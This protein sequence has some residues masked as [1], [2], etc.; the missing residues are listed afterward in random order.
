[1]PVKLLEV[2]GKQEKEERPGVSIVPGEVLNNCDLLGQG[3]VRVRVPSFGEE[4][5]ARL[6]AP[7]GGPNGGLQY[8][9]RP[10]DEVLLAYVHSNPPCS[11]LLNGLWNTSDRMPVSNPVE[12]MHKRVLRSGL[13]EA[14]PAHEIELDDVLQSVNIKSATDQQITMDPTSIQMQSTGGTLSV[15]MDVAT[16]TITIKA[17]GVLELNAPIIKI[18]GQAVDIAGKTTRVEGSTGCIIKGGLVAIN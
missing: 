5:W 3:K 1:M 8:V 16:Q 14:G 10:G 15:K 18:N 17:Q 6:T 11:Y 7:G 12:L 13:T 9:P 2:G 4:V